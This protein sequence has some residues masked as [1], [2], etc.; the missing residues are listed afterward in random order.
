MPEST[1]S[2][3]AA[4]I[5]VVLP[6]L[7]EAGSLPAVLADLRALQAT[8]LTLD[9]VLV[10][11]GSTDGTGDIGREAGITVLVEPRRGYGTAVQRGFAHLAADPPAVVV[12]LDADHADDP[13]RLPDLVQPVLTDRADLVL[14]D[15]TLT[16]EPHALS[17]VQVF[18]NA[19][20]TWLIARTTGH[21]YRDMGPFRAVRWE[22]LVQLE[23]EDPT[24]GWNVEMQMKAVHHGLRILELPLPYR[25][26]RAGRSKIGGS[27]TGATRAGVR[28]LQAVRRYR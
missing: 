17:A 8:G 14:A 5:G 2:V 11:N 26:R 27:L 13:L 21:R 15:R 25:R 22:S 6:A 7:D 16:A 18:G 23:M 4:R 3:P 9:V 20:S 1:P 10:D 28:I 24:W 12:V 19:L